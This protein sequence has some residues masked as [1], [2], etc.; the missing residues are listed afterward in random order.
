MCLMFWHSP[1]QP[2]NDA[3]NPPQPSFPVVM[4]LVCGPRGIRGAYPR[5]L[6]GSKSK[7]SRGCT[8][9]PS[10]SNPSSPTTRIP[11]SARSFNTNATPLRLISSPGPCQK[12][13]T[14]CCRH[15][16]I[17]SRCSFGALI[18]RRCHLWNLWS[19]QTGFQFG[20]LRSLTCTTCPVS[21]LTT[22]PPPGRTGDPARRAPR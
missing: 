15:M 5:S 13:W 6:S 1:C 9:L 19:F 10:S 3:A 4:G 18:D 21:S 2:R 22:Y 7:S 17:R 11:R 16:S 12:N 20:L 14:R 8:S